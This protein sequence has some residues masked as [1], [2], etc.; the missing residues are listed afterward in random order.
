MSWGVFAELNATVKLNFDLSHYISLSYHFVLYH[1]FLY[2]IG[3]L[4]HYH[5]MNSWLMAR[6]VFCKVDEQPNKT[7]CFCSGSSCH[8]DKHEWL[9]SV[10]LTLCQKSEHSSWASFSSPLPWEEIS[11]LSLL[12]GLGSAHWWPQGAREQPSAT[13]P[14]GEE[15]YRGL[16]LGDADTERKVG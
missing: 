16:L 12:L 8:I 14:W 3:Y 5:R 1:C 7:Q 15:G 2:D 11:S 13:A 10:K 6:N 9:Q 4:S